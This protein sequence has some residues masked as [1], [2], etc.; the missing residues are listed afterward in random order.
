MTISAEFHIPSSKHIIYHFQ[1]FC[2]S[3]QIFSKFITCLPAVV[4]SVKPSIP[5]KMRSVLLLIVITFG[6]LVN[7]Q[8][9]PNW[10]WAKSSVSQGGNSDY[11]F[12]QS[13]ATDADGNVYATGFFQSDNISFGPNAFT[14]SGAADVFLL[15]YDA[16]GN[17]IWA[18][19][20]GGSEADYAYSVAVDK[21]GYIYITGSF[22]SPTITFGNTTLSRTHASDEA[23]IVKYS[24]QGNVLWARNSSSSSAATASGTCVTTD[25]AGNVYLSGY[26]LANDVSFGNVTLNNIGAT[27]VSFIVK[28]DAAGNVLWAKKPTTSGGVSIS[29][30]IVDDAGNMFITGWNHFATTVFG[31]ITLTN[32]APGADLI[33]VAKLDPSGNAIWAKNSQGGGTMYSWNATMDHLGNYYVGGRYEYNGD[34]HFDALT[35]HNSNKNT[36][37][38]YIVKYDANGNAVWAKSIT[39]KGLESVFGLAVDTANNVYAAGCFSMGYP[40]IDHDSVTIDGLSFPFP[41][42]ANNPAFIAE[43]DP[44]GNLLNATTMPAG[45][46]RQFEI[47]IGNDN[48]LVIGS[49]FESMTLSM[50][51]TT[52]TRTGSCDA[53]VAKMTFGP[54]T[55]PPAVTAGTYEVFPN[56]LMSSVATLKANESL[57]NAS[58]TIYNQQGLIVR[59]T[60]NIS[61]REINI[62]R[63]NLPAG[64][65]F[66]YLKQGDKLLMTKKWLLAN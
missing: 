41:A 49:S 1:I 4:L 5:Y 22:I 66:I 6:N 16:L 8:T 38:G 24:P 46:G 25:K 36:A 26:A 2:N 28:Y 31:N 58:V 3:I 10:L 44:S 61:G 50:G 63:D 54:Y 42:N 43:F 64:F 7:A 48:A 19:R 32:P 9:A 20:A 14:K 45:G 37:D 34:V 55:P 60:K 11:D 29:K 35:L 23:F 56:P 65:Y 13:V 52:L 51:S 62:S 27:S 15:K 59:E 17:L 21:S 12:V 18:K 40:T 53:L 57:T 47:C 39:G 33:Y 30:I